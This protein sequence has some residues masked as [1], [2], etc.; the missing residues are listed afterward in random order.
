MSKSATEPIPTTGQTIQSDQS[1]P[2]CLDAVEAVG[3]VKAGRRVARIIVLYEDGGRSSYALP[4][5]VAP[6]KDWAKTKPGRA[7]LGVMAGERRPLKGETIAKLADY[8]YNG[9]FR[10]AMKGL[11]DQGEIE[12]DGDG[13]YVLT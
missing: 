6:L 13:M 2:V 8:A 7:I 10:Q 11:E 1:S 9:S 4:L 5:P 3:A 12:R